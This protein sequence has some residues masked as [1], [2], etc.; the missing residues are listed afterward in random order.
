MFVDSA[1]SLHNNGDRMRHEP[2]SQS[3]NKKDQMMFDDLELQRISA[4]NPNSN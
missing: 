2:K 1:L 4:K 3:K